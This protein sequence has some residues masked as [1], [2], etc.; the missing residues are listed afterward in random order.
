[1][2]QL[3][4]LWAIITA[5]QPA[6]PTTVVAVCLSVAAAA[7]VVTP[8]WR[9]ARNAITTV[10]EAG[11]GFVATLSGRRLAG[12]RLHSDTSG[13]TVSVG[14]P[15]GPG[16]VA[17]LLSGYPAP[18]VL[19][20]AA[21]GLVGIGHGVAFLWLLLVILVLV[22]VQIR[23][24]YGLLVVL[25]SGGAVVAVT[26]LLDP[27]WQSAVATTVAGFLGFGALRASV[28]LQGARRREGAGRGRGSSDADQLARLTHLPAILW[29][30]VFVVIAFTGAVVGTI[31]LMRIDAQA[32][33][34][35]IGW[36][37]N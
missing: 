3:S 5:A 29:V 17:T 27:A 1:M 33:V 13:V 26:L 4:A 28:E 35:D 12:I 21:A 15:R 23:N 19:G 7:V 11:H 2:E 32:T 10:H 25:V 37:W 20:L 18:A 30:A 14:K 34:A 9:V 8:V 6:L 31:L 16:M 22:L 36:L 24:W